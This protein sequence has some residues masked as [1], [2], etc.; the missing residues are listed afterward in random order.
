[1]VSQADVTG[2]VLCGGASRRMGRDKALL[3]WH[4]RSLIE[5]ALEALAPVAGERLLACGRS[6]RY[7]ELGFSLV[8]DE[9][10]DGGP[11]AGLEAGLAAAQGAWVVAVACDMPRLTPG[12]VEGLLEHAGAADADGAV[13]EVDGRVEPLCGVYHRRCLPAVRA[14]LA[15]GRRRMIDFW[16]GTTERGTPVRVLRLASP[17]GSAFANLNT[18]DDLAREGGER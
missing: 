3:E 17:N 4:G 11:L 2:L 7:E 1:M 13:Y 10:E 16:S 15:A 12:L 8:L 6:P 14:S 18:P 5:R 9:T